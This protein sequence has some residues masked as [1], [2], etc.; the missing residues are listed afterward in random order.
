MKRLTWLTNL[1][2]RLS[3]PTVQMPIRHRPGSVAACSAAIEKLEARQLLTSGAAAVGF[4]ARVNSYTPGAQLLPATAVDAAGDSVTVWA[5]NGQDGSNYGVYGQRYNAA[6]VAVGNEFR[7][8]TYTTSFQRFPSVAMDAAGDFVVTWQSFNQDGNGS[9]IF[10]QRYN[11]AGVAQGTEFKVNTHTMG[12]QDLSSVAINSTGAFVIAWESAGQDGNNYGIYAQRYNSAGVAQGGEFR[13]NTFTTGSQSI[14]SAAMD[15]AG[16]FVVTWQSV[17]QDGN[18]SGIYAQRYNAAGTA[19]G[20]EFKVNTYTTSVQDFPSVAMDTT[21]NFV[22]TWQS[23]QDGNSSFGVYAQRYNSAGVA[24]GSEFQVNSVIALNQTNPSVA[25]DTA[26]DFVLTWQS[27]GQD[28]SGWG[29]YAKRFDATGAP[30]GG[31]FRVNTF[32][33]GSQSLP[34]IGMDTHGDFIVTW[35]SD[36][37]DGSNYG[38]YTQR[39]VA[40]VGPIV[41]AVLEGTGPRVVKSGDTLASS[42]TSF[43]VMFSDDLFSFPVGINSVTNPANWQLTR[44]GIDVSNQISMLSFAFD[45]NTNRYVATVAFNQPLITGAYQLVASQRIEDTAGRSLDGEADGVAGGD[46]RLGFTAAKTLKAGLE[47]RV[48]TYTTGQQFV[49]SVASDTS[50][51]YVVAWS[52]TQEA[53]GYGVYAQRYNSSGIAQGSEFHVNTY[54]TGIQANPSVAMDAAGN[55]VIAWVSH[56]DGGGYGIYAQRY[57]A[58]GS[59]QG[60]EF[61]INTYTTNN[62]FEPAVAMDAAGD[63]VICWTSDGQDGSNYGIYARGYNSL[64]VAQGTEFEVNTYT[65]GVQAAPTVAADSAGD[66]VI[67]WSSAGQDGD[68]YCIRAQRFNSTGIRQGPEFQVNTYTTSDQSFPSVAMNAIGD[69]VVTWS[70]SGQDGDGD[71]VYGQRFDAAG[72]TEGGEFQVNSYTTGDQ[73]F[74]SDAMDAAGDFVVTWQSN[75]QD[76]SDDGVYGQRFNSAGIAQSGEFRVNTFTTV[77]QAYPSVAMDQVGDFVVVWESLAQDN[78]G[79]GIYSQRYQTDVAPW[80]S[81]IETAPL[82]AAAPLTT[83]VTTSLQTTDVDSDLLVGCTIQ[84]TSNYRGNQ[85]V[86]GFTNTPK[87]TAD[88]NVATGTLT[89]SGK[90]TVANY[91]AALRN[92]TY[93]NTSLMPVTSPARTVSFQVSDGLISSNVVSRDLN[94]QA[95]STPAVLSGVSGTGTYNENNPAILISQNLTITDPDVAFLSSATVSFTSWQ[96]GDRVDFNNIFALSHNFTENLAS[97]TAS[98]T[99]TGTAT[100]DHYQT[101]LRSVKYWNVSDNPATTQR[102]V[103]Y[104]VSDG[105]SQSNSVGRN[106]NVVTVNDAPLLSAI[107]ATPLVYQANN[108]GF[109]AQPISATLLAA[110]PDSTN[111]VKATVKISAG[112]QNNSAGHDILSFTNQLGITGSYNATT[113]TLTLT[114][115]SSVANYRAALRSVKFSTSGSNV[116]SANR[117]L[118]I[119][120]TDDSGSPTANSAVVTRDVTV[121]TTNTPPALSGVPSAALAYVRGAVAE[122]LA[123]NAVVLDADGINLYGATIQITGNYQNGQDVLAVTNGSGIT[124]S[125]DAATGKLT[126]SGT[127]SLASYQAVL[128]TATYKTNSSGASTATRTITLIVNDGLSVSSAVTRTITLT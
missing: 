33:F 66:F 128:R 16:D 38:I 113:G 100:L 77:S 110:D 102:V 62:Q 64:G 75:G 19:Q 17:G 56:Q 26:G 86:L 98:L 111:C 87:I 58:A 120:L 35:Q 52:S 70:S 5:S 126:L 108:P 36:G 109:L 31:E 99:I 124:G 43:S 80:L 76:G 121:V 69:F 46:F 90:D 59:P 47:T 122:K 68:G 30:V 73:R 13:V 12:A 101:L 115:A 93:H 29:V 18:S 79:S 6:G 118:S 11:S 9:G 50:G 95:T 72:F 49:P 107:E 116:S 4:E 104:I 119:T 44:Y 117:T 54:T 92:V 3:A 1:Y 51:D 14:P 25:I 22:V 23:Y 34:S 97:H 82:N 28:G 85:D 67:A 37:Q 27:N 81:E 78:S 94:V 71:G 88:W 105:S 39:Y 7:I 123:P 42:I 55:F 74:N 103:A 20:T 106:I 60:S 2:T 57:N 96:G 24:Q 40:T 61:R 15:A 63:F 21:G 41:T 65:T 91:R 53:S 89:L 32:T 10:A 45:L 127:A 112:Y 8:N 83:P 125:F 84:I 48:N 114:G